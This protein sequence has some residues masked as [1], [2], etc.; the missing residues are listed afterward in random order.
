MAKKLWALIMN[1]PSHDHIEGRIVPHWSIHEIGTKT[2]L[3][4]LVSIHPYYSTTFQ[5]QV[6]RRDGVE[7]LLAL[8][9]G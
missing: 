3:Q 6:V 5:A 1:V 7:A 8:L 4:R 9:N 2:K